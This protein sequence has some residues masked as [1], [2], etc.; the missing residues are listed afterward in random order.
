MMIRQSQVGNLVARNHGFGRG[1]LYLEMSRKQRALN[2]PKTNVEMGKA[3]APM[4]IPDCLCPARLG[5]KTLI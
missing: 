3:T 4:Y 5:P 1:G 2:H